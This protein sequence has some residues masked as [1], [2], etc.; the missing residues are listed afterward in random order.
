MSRHHLSQ[1]FLLF[2]LSLTI[3][4]SC[5]SFV[6]AAEI[7][8]NTTDQTNTSSLKLNMTPPTNAHADTKKSLY[9]LLTHG[10]I[11]DGYYIYKVSAEN[12]ANSNATKAIQKAFNEAATNATGSRPYK[13]VIEPGSYTLP[14]RLLIY[15][16]TYLYM[17]GV[18]LTQPVG[19]SA[20]MLKVGKGTDSHAGYY[21]ENITID[22]GTS[23]GVWD[24]SGNSSTAI[25]IAHTKNFTMNNVTLQNTTDAHLMEIAGVDGFVVRNCTFK[26]QILVKTRYYEAIQFDYLVSDHFKGFAMQDLALQNILVDGCTFSNVPRAIGGHTSILNNYMNNVTITNNLFANCTSAALQLMSFMNCTISENTITNCPRGVILYSIRRSGE[27]TYLSTTPTNESG[28]LATTPTNYIAPPKDQNIVVT[29][30]HIHLQGSDKHEASYENV[31][32]FLGGFDYSSGEQVP[33]N[34]DILPAG[35]YYL[36]GATISDNT[37]VTTD[38]GILLQHTHNARITDNHISFI[39]N[40]TNCHGILL[41]TASLDNIVENNAIMNC[42]GN[43]ISLENASSAGSISA[44][45]ITAPATCGIYVSDSSS[46]GNIYANFIGSPGY[47]GI[48]CTQGSIN[49]I[50]QNAIFSTKDNALYINDG[51]V[52]S[53]TKSITNRIEQNAGTTNTIQDNLIQNC[54]DKSQFISTGS[55]CFFLSSSTLCFA[56]LFGSAEQAFCTKVP[57]SSAKYTAQIS[58]KLPE[59]SSDVKQTEYYEINVTQLPSNRTKVSKPSNI[60]CFDT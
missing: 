44:N 37:I 8:A 4:T 58:S 50:K 41:C 7:T 27:G 57:D 51:V 17:E 16:N 49:S 53:I 46:V 15:S 42:P 3:L 45:T 40:R 5:T 6:F 55:C 1:F 47:A 22:G 9:S 26:N 14:K 38:C 12:I 34:G 23:G 60:S 59:N 29:N 21:Y 30:N 18:T 20:N 52:N 33:S 19:T 39:E 35:D 48:F 24:E 32:I 43:A 13:V 2:S 28:I 56:M 11:V 25:K 31:A 10:S 36:S 54:S